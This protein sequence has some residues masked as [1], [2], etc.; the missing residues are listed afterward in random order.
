MKK[1][2]KKGAPGSN[3]IKRGKTAI[4]EVREISAVKQTGEL[5]AITVCWWLRRWCC[6]MQVVLV[7]NLARSNRLSQELVPADSRHIPV[8]VIDQ[9][10]V[11]CFSTRIT[12]PLQPVYLVPCIRISRY[13]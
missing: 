13:M 2:K 12:I 3:S 1:Q 5:T 9:N 4:K 11:G 7:A 6:C 8:T 10:H